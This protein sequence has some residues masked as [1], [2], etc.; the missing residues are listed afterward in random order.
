VNYSN[1]S[2]IVHHFRHVGDYWFN[3]RFRHGMSVV[4]ALVLGES[5]NSGLRNLGSRI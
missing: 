4:S 5:L 2:P 3:I 1:L